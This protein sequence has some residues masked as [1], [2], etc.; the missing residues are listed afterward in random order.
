MEGHIACERRLG[1]SV[2]W[3]DGEEERGNGDKTLGP[4]KVSMECG[5]ELGGGA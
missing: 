4:Q 3:S 5:M 1:A 2:G